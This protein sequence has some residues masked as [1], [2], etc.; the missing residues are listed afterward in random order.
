MTRLCTIVVLF[1][2]FF[3]TNAKA[4]VFAGY[5]AFCGLPVVVGTDSMIASARTDQQNRKFIHIDPG[6]MNNWTM[7]RMFTLAHECAHHLLGH[8]NPLGQQQRYYG[9]TAT[10][11]LEADCWAARKLKEIGHE[12]DLKATILQRANAGHFAD[13]GYPTG[14]ERA[15]NML[16]CIGES[17]PERTRPA[18]CRNIQVPESY[19]SYDVVM[20]TNQV[21]YQ[22]CGCNN[23]G[24]CGCQHQ[25]DLIQVPVQVP[26]QRSRMVTRQVCD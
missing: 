5:D 22:H 20:Q 25:L 3:S 15:Q 24:Q 14:E 18:Q 23:F 8:T 19:T 11:E 4:D 9:G 10:Q 12:S 16:S 17:S 26:V 1:L 13:P 7:S 21:P 6:A 2:A